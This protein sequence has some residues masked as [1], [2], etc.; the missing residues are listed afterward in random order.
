MTEMLC[1]PRA[2]NRLCDGLVIVH[3]M[4]CRRKQ[5]FRTIQLSSGSELKMLKEA[6]YLG[7]R[8][9]SVDLFVGG[10]GSRSG[11]IV[12]SRDEDNA[13]RLFSCLPLSG[14]MVQSSMVVLQV[15]RG[16]PYEYA[17]LS[18]SRGRRIKQDQ[19]CL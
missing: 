7:H 9:G 15:T 3:Q 2:L 5:R 13:F 19:L 18:P 12:R 1:L 8:L 17:V 11:N 16:L 6:T 10:E 4:P 14:D